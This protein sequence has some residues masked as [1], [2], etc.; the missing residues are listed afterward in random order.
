[1]TL[2]A[3][4]LPFRCI[5]NDRWAASTVPGPFRDELNSAGKGDDGNTFQFD[6][7]SWAFNLKT[8][9]FDASGTYK[10]TVVSGNEDD[11]VIDPT[12]MVEFVIE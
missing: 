11:H 4:R 6:G 3:D 1:M 12:C 9:N 5:A 2:H 8:S 10:I 7:S